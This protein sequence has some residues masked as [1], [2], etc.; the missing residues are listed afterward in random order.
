MAEIKLSNEKVKVTDTDNNVLLDANVLDLYYLIS[1]AQ[2]NL[3]DA[4]TRTR[5]QV[6][7][8]AVNKEYGTSFTWSQILEIL[9]DVTEIIE[10]L[11]K[12]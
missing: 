3:E 7:A 9:Q 4:P 1:I 10:D 8:D 11:K 2:E 6:A 12:N 5:L